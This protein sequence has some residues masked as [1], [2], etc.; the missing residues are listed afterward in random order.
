MNMGVKWDSKKVFVDAVQLAIALPL[1]VVATMLLG[2]TPTHCERDTGFH[3]ANPIADDWV[4]RKYVDE[5]HVLFTASNHGKLVS[6]LLA[7]DVRVLDDKKP[8]AAV[9]GFHNQH[10]LPL[11]IGLLI[12]TS[13]SVDIRFEFEQAAAANFLAQTV[14]PSQDSA[15]VMGF[16]E[17]PHM[18]QNFTNNTG[19]L[20]RG[21]ATL[22]DNQGYTALFDAVVAACRKLLHHPEG[23]FVARTLVVV[24]DG[25]DNM[26]EASLQDSILVAQ[27]A[28]VTVYTIAIDNEWATFGSPLGA[29]NLKQLAEQTGG[30]AFFAGSVGRLKA[31]FARA[32]HELRSRYAISYRPADF[33]L[34]GHYRRIQIT[35]KQ[36]GRKLKVHSR[37]GYYATNLTSLPATRGVTIRDEP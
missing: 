25:D 18:A 16:S 35:A 29:Q 2:Q 36:S 5:V 15:F 31:A 20:L 9:L 11:R 26:S 19:M 28:E 32:S 14:R 33:T 10:D 30:R 17:F 34:D 3:P 27:Q 24:S 8:A 7:S 23:Q 21:L 13:G 12:D 6:D 22:S 1:F 4:F 37:K